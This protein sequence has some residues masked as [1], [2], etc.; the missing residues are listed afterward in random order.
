MKRPAAALP[1]AAPRLAALLLWRAAAS[2][3]RQSPY[4][5]DPE[6]LLAERDDLRAQLATKNGEFLAQHRRADQLVLRVRSLERRLEAEEHEE[7]VLKSKLDRVRAIL[8][9]DG[10]APA[11]VT[12]RVAPVPALAARTSESARPATGERR[13][14]RPAWPS[15]PSPTAAR[16][17]V[18]A[19]AAAAAPLVVASSVTPEHPREEHQ[20]SV[21]QG[22]GQ[23][24]EKDA[25][26]GFTDLEQELRE[27]DRRI[28][29]IDRELREEDA[30]GDRRSRMAA[31]E[32]PARGPGGARASGLSAG[33][34]AD[35]TTEAV[36][37]SPQ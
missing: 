7:L 36:V 27:E 2:A 24:G 26:S 15:R 31:V 32:L 10:E 17:A 19:R 21:D 1:G 22:G 12:P 33:A 14:K 37:A 29:A 20:A 13:T 25:G 28:D 4:L 18:A 8:V 9:S 30:P 23:D 34:E 35:T 11:N 5:E 3:Q 16:P 6:T